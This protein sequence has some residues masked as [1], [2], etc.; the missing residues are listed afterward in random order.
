M[1]LKGAWR[2]ILAGLAL[3]ARSP[4]VRLGTIAP[5]RSRLPKRVP[6][7]ENSSPTPPAMG[8]MASYE[9][10]TVQAIDFPD[11]PSASARRLLDL[12]P[13]KAGAPLQREK[14]RQSIQ[15]LHATGR[16]ADIQVEA[17]RTA[18]ARSY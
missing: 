1:R 4:S 2:R 15:V 12:I 16:F 18:G 13:Q 5:R 17:E 10:L 14:V 7:Q 6:R 9:G 8:S 11:L 3:A